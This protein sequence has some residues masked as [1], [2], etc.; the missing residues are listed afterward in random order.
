MSSSQALSVAAAEAT[1]HQQTASQHIAH[2]VHQ[3]M[4]NIAH[5]VHQHTA[6]YIDHTAHQHTAH[7]ADIADP[8]DNHTDTRV[9]RKAHHPH[10]LDCFPLATHMREMHGRSSLELDIP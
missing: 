3:H 9:H 6:Y 2:I 1:A 5:T 7:T 10:R 4:S 8:A